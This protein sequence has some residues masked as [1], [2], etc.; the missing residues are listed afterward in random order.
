MSSPCCIWETCSFSW[1]P[2]SLPK[3]ALLLLHL[4]WSQPASP[5]HLVQGW[6]G[7]QDNAESCSRTSCQA[8]AGRGSPRQ[9]SV[10]GFQWK[11]H[12]EI[13]SGRLLD[14]SWQKPFLLSLRSSSPPSGRPPIPWEEKLVLGTSFPS[15][16][17]IP[18]FC[19]NFHF[20]LSLCLTK[21]LH[22]ENKMSNTLVKM[23]PEI[24]A[25]K[26]NPWLS[27]FKESGM[28]K[29]EFVHWNISRNALSLI[30]LSYKRRDLDWSD[31]F[32]KSRL[33]I[34]DIA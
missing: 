25:F 10:V 28:S 11:F 20:P 14:D 1:S 15:L 7:C 24:T 26:R 5:H 4:D 3:P 2:L 29:E 22:R 6:L 27:H 16:S 18:R 32:L 13:A 8:A 9:P 30:L 31:N 12:Q 19:L 23:V 33:D 34:E 17:A 21:R